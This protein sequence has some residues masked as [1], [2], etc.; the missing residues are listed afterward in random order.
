M[1]DLTKHYPLILAVV[2]ML[3]GFGVSIAV[4]KNQVDSINAR[5]EKIEDQNVYIEML[6]DLSEVK[7]ELAKP[8]HLRDDP[9]TGKEGRELARRIEELERVVYRRR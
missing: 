9:F 3:T 4:M 6:R 8:E 5:L 2:T 7:V 1:P